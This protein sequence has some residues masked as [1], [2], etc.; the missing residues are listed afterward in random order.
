[1]DFKQNSKTEIKE[2]SFGFET[3]E[4]KDKEKKDGKTRK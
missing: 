3:N 2:P 1:M 4:H